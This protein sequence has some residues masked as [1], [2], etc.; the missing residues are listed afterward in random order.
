M[1][2]PDTFFACLRPTRQPQLTPHHQAIRL[3]SRAQNRAW[4]NRNPRTPDLKERLRQS[5]DP[6]TY[7]RYERS[8]AAHYNSLESFPLLAAAVIAGNVARLPNEAMNRFVVGMGALRTMYIV[9]YINSASQRYSHVRSVIWL[10]GL[11]WCL[12]MLWKAGSALV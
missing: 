6:D 7:A 8:E 10:T 5:L 3:V 12:R 11:G 1:P 9:A 4:D 2:L